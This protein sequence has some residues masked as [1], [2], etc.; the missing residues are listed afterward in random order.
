[1]QTNHQL[2]IA[3][4]T[5]ALGLQLPAFAGTEAPAVAPAPSNSGDWCTWLQN[6]PGTL[7]KNKENPYFQE[8][9]LE[10]RLQFQMAHLDGEDVNGEDFDSN[11]NE[12]RRARL[13]AKAKFFQYFGAKF[14]VDLVGDERINNEPNSGL[15]WGY[16]QIDEAYLSFDLGKALGQSAFDSLMVNYGRQKFVL[17][18]EARTSSTKLLTVERSAISN[19]VYGSARPTGLSVDGTIDQWSFTGALYSSTTDNT[20][21]NS[22]QGLSGWQDSIIYYASA[23]YQATKELNVRADFVYN[24]ADIAS[25]DDSVLAYEWASSLN[26][27]YDA[28]AWG[29]IGD[30]TFGD[31]G[32]TSLAN[33]STRDDTFWGVM[34]MPYY[35][36]MDEKLQ[37]VG[38]YQYGGAESSDGIRINS[39]YGRARGTGDTTGIDV[40]DG[41]GDEHHSL[42][43]GLN[44]YLCGHNAKI[45]GGIEYQTM[46]TPAG[47]FD[48]LT[49]LLAFRTFF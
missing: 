16:E 14:Q 37:L 33:D 25:G 2:P 24:D 3:A 27:E 23:G 29:V 49:Y 28:G 45:Q 11:F 17:G 20:E 43:A 12:F 15:G 35:W 9:Q 38:Q 7:Y 40:N 4:L 1:M 10:G 46:D 6:K 21:F 18:Q 36:I 48:T 26:A 42:Y 8:F 32:G 31:N 41:R 44:Y 5:V 34:V 30:F 22:N 47:D 19:K 39:R 13:G